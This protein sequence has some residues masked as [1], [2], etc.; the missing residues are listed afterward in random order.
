[1]LIQGFFVASRIKVNYRICQGKLLGKIISETQE[2]L[3]E[4]TEYKTI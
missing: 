1:M 2:R 3:L 4:E